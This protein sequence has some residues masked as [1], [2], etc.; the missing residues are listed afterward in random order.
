MNDNLLKLELNQRQNNLI[1][2]LNVRPGKNL[3]DTLTYVSDLQIRERKN[4]T[5]RLIDELEKWIIQFILNSFEEKYKAKCKFKIE[6]GNLKESLKNELNNIINLLSGLK[7]TG[8]EALTFFKENSQAIGIINFIWKGIKNPLGFL[9]E[10]NTKKLQEKAHS[11][12]LTHHVSM[13]EDSINEFLLALIK[14]VLEFINFYKV[15]YI[16]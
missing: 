8:S 10:L 15:K 14:N 4:E 11:K 5:E 13:L 12:K 7:F 3:E 16:L 6:C 9:N 1:E 2:L